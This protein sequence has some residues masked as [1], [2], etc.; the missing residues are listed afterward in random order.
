MKSLNLYY[1]IK[2]AFETSTHNC[3]RFSEALDSINWD[4][5]FFADEEYYFI[6]DDLTICT[7][8]LDP[9]NMKWEAS[10]IFTDGSVLSFA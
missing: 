3:N 5:S 8:S 2:E 1:S 6:K 7:P 4:S 9:F 10:A